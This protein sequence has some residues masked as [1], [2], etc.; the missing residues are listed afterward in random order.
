[1]STSLVSAI[2]DHLDRFA[3]SELTGLFS[4]RALANDLAT[5]AERVWVG[6]PQLRPRGQTVVAP[7]LR[8][9]VEEI[10]AVAL[11]AQEFR[12]ADLRVFVADSM[13]ALPPQVSQ[14]MA[15]AGRVYLRADDGGDGRRLEVLGDLAAAKHVVFLVPGMTN[16]LDNYETQLRPK[17]VALYNEM[18]AQL[19]SGARVA[20]IAW[21]GYNTPDATVFGLIDAA[22]SVSAERG[23]RQLEADLDLLHQHGMRAHVTIVGHSYGSVVAGRAMKDDDRH[24]LPVNDVVVVGSP[25]M[26]ARSRGEL[27][28]PDVRLWAGKTS[29]PGVPRAVVMAS[30]GSLFL[31]DKGLRVIGGTDVVPMAPV[32]GP[33]PA[34]KG[35]GARS[36]PTD[37][38]GHSEYFTPGTRSLKSIA[39]VAVGFPKP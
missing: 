20:V 31:L 32:H 10:A 36:L 7:I 26:D 3:S 12:R 24:R 30:G 15:A 13:K 19:G 29:S 4:L 23:A 9:V 39:R 27:R 21:L 18:R 11:V 37:G 33:D 38:H 35:F 6:C 17:A 22:T 14:R 8:D 5:R 34:T 25:G 28:S 1:V 2:P 16:S